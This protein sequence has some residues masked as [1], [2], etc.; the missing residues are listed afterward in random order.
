VIEIPFE[1][2]SSLPSQKLPAFVEPEGLLPRSQ[3]SATC[4]Y[5]EPDWSKSHPPKRFLSD[6]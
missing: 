3:E 1:N 4:P 5:L 2:H 6:P